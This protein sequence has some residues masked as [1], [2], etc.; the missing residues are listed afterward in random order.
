MM[1]VTAHGWLPV[2]TRL[3]DHRGAPAAPAVGA[4]MTMRSLSL[5]SVLLAFTSLAAPAVAQATSLP[6][7]GTWIK[8]NDYPPDMTLPVWFTG[9]TV[10]SPTES[11]AT[12]YTWTSSRY[13]RFDITDWLVVGDGFKVFDN[14]VLA[15]TFSGKPDYSAI[16]GCPYNNPLDLLCHWTD[17]PDVAFADPLF[18]QG[19]I[20]F[21]PGSH[22]IKVEEIVMPSTFQDATVTFRAQAQ[23]VPEPASLV[24][25]GSGLFGIAAGWRRARRRAN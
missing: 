17:N 7:D 13:V 15:G 21:S 2:G 19:S 11:G 24:L 22:A 8:L 12:A 23:A 1:V 5:A 16:A 14:D 3:A 6:L 18:N 4:K 20:L 10:T 25:L 9:T